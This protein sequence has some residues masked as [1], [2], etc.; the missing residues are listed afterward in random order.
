VQW[1][2]EMLV[3][4]EMTETD[5]TS[6]LANVVDFRYPLDMY[7]STVSYFDAQVGALMAYLEAQGLYDQS[8]IIVTAPHGEILQ[9]E[10]LP[11]HHF[12]LTPDTLHVPLI[13]KL[14]QEAGHRKTGI[15]LGGGFDLIDLFPTTMD[16][17]GL[18]N[19]PAVSGVSR[20]D[21]IK[22]GEEI[23]AHDSFAAGLHQFSHSVCRPPHLFAREKDQIGMPTFHLVVGG[24]GE[25]VYDTVSGEV[26]S[27]KLPDSVASLRQSWEVH[28]GGQKSEK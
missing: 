21:A 28:V 10:S 15:R 26:H 11:Y 13:M 20:W 14:P 17:L 12:L 22:S 27:S 24:A 16:I 2:K 4:L 19:P 5:I 7:L 23:P 8:L 6:W 18:K 9:D 3:L 1:L 25:I